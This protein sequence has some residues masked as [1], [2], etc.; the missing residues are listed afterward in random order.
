MKKSIFATMLVLT[1]FFR[2]EAELISSHE[3]KD[4]I[5]P[6]STPSYWIGTSKWSAESGGSLHMKSTV[7]NNNTMCRAYAPVRQLKYQQEMEFKITLGAKGQGELT[8]G[9]ICYTI[10][11]PEEII[12]LPG[13]STQLAAE[14]KT[15]V[16][17]V[18]LP[19]AYR[20][21][22]PMIQLCGD[23]EAFVSN[24]KLELTAPGKTAAAST[25]TPGKSSVDLRTDRFN[26]GISS[27]NTP[28]YWPGKTESVAVDGFKVLKLSSGERNGEF[29]GR[30]FTPVQRNTE[31]IPGKKLKFRLL[32]SGT[33][34]FVSGILAYGPK[35]SN[36]GYEYISGKPMKLEE[37]FAVYEFE[38]ELT[39]CYRQIMPYIQ[40]LGNNTIFVRNFSMRL[41]TDNDA[42]ITAATPLQIIT[43]GDQASPVSFNSSMPESE[44]FITQ[45]CKSSSTV[46]IQK[47]DANGNISAIPGKNDSG[48]LTIT[49]ARK[50]AFAGAYVFTE[51][52][53]IYNATNATAKKIKLEKPLNVLFIGDSLSDYYRGYNYIDR[54][55]FWMN[56]YNPGKFNFHNAGVGGDYILRVVQRMNGRNG[57]NPAYRQEMYNDIFK[58]KYDI[59][60]IFL[61]QNDTRS[62]RKT[63]FTKPLVSTAEQR[64]AFEE[65]IAIL[66]VN[67]PQ[68]KIV[69]ISPSPSDPRRFINYD[70]TFPAGKPITMYGAPALVD[71]YDKVNREICSKH[72]F[73]YVDIL[74]P[75]R[76]EKDQASLFIADG[77]HLSDKGG[78]VIAELL[79]KYFA[80]IQK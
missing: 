80:G 70:K 4:R 59:I 39:K 21:V 52:A 31:F 7:R 49:A 55:A 78:R 29:F 24:F 15:F 46:A 75:M 43:A 8:A 64:K 79:L 44:I 3:F 57:K 41:F 71:A 6:W 68:A 50:G 2:L 60:F 32:A 10:G 18:K 72:G 13:K 62:D 47:A 56:K 25:A 45:S 20:Q 19:E 76:A 37:N 16:Y 17:T 38:I 30:S 63:R 77:V 65:L 48:L 14:E 12:Y 11:T 28:K 58:E 26:D 23:G 36:P 22:L 54:L 67:E 33:G 61:G 40:I 9:L 53:A 27:W 74:N 73:D 5:A 51:D 1:A 42:K 69:M 66:K 35:G 34:E